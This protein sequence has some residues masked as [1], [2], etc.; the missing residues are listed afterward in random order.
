MNPAL[1][2]FFYQLC[3]FSRAPITLV[4]VFDGPHRPSI[5]RGKQVVHCPTQ[6]IDHVKNLIAAFGYYFRDAPGEAE[7]ELAKLN[8]LGYID[9]ILTEDSDAFVFGAQ[10]VIRT[11][12]PTVNDVC[13]IYTADRIHNTIGLSAD[14]LLLFALLSGGDYHPG[15]YG[16][17]PRI[18][19]MVA[20]SNFSESLV[21]ILTSLSGVPLRRA[22]HAWRQDLRLQLRTNSTGVFAR[23]YPKLATRIPDTFPNVANAFKYLNPLTSWSAEYNGLEP[24][25]HWPPREPGIGAITR[26]C[27]ERFGWGDSR[28]LKRDILRKFRRNLWPGIVQRM[29]SSVSDSSLIGLMG[30]NYYS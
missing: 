24:V 26:F 23:R 7:A 25:T 20:D 21:H 30:L 17:G 16:C 2:I 4:F 22:L 14:G 27:M 9:G 1:R 28:E 3:Q 19:R 13:H 8:A 29:L 6:L 5:K 15:V 18:A 10:C 11:T 12:G